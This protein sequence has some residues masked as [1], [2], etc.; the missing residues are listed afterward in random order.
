[1]SDAQEGSKDV[2]QKSPMSWL[3]PRE[4]S[5]AEAAGEL[6]LIQLV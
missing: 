6:V 5:E 2:A 4:P 1:M 3:G